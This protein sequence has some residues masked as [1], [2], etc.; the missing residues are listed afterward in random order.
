MDIGDKVKVTSGENK[1]KVGVIVG[2]GAWVET[3][4]GQ[5]IPKTTMWSIRFEDGTE[6]YI[7]ETQL[8]LA[9]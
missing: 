7:G 9:E 4:S 2:R 3:P 6:K 5:K 1:G 8:E